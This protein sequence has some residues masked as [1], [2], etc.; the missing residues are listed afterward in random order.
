MRDLNDVNVVIGRAVAEMASK[1][2]S[3]TR[4]NLVF[5]LQQYWSSSA[6]QEKETY[7]SALDIVRNSKNFFS[8]GLLR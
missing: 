5:V 2:E 4:E 7:I 1:G 6:D 3:I 8:E